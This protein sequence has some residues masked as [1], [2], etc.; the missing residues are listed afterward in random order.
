VSVARATV[1]FSMP[2][3]KITVILLRTRDSFK[4]KRKLK[5]SQV[6]LLTF[7]SPLY[8]DGDV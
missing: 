1:Q 2:V 7:G 8:L 5:K 6:F 3:E 4:R